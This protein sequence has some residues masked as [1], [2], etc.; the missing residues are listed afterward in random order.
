MPE[1]NPA[2]Q[3]PSVDTR[4][5]LDERA[6]DILFREART[7]RG[8]LPRIVPISLVRHA[9]EL[10]RLGATS[11]NCQPMRLLLLTSPAA[12]ERLIPALHPGNVEQTRQ[13]SL[14]A[15]VSYDLRFFEN[16]P[17]L[18]PYIPNATGMFEG[19]AML[20]EDTAFRNSTLQGAYFGL[21]LR[22]LGLDVSSMSG[23]DREMV[24]TEF[25]PGGRVRSNWL[26]NIGSADPSKELP[27]GPR[28]P[29]EDAVA[30]L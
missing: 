21:T 13:A 29:F 23:F 11:M 20:A 5:P 15:I 25:F 2:D 30:V 9:Y 19:N 3:I 24:D 8:F 28:L 4:P 17:T 26:M 1:I 16:L 10:A 7:P 18:F 14:T 12:K 6:I 22:A 27:R